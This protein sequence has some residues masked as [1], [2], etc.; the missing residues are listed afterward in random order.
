MTTTWTIAIDWD[1]NG[2]YTGTYDDVTSRVVS[3]EW[4]GGM[5]EAF[6]D[7]ADNSVL[8]LVLDNSD[9]RYSPEYASSPLNTKVLPYRPIRIQSNDG[10]TTR[11]HWVGW[12][13]TIQPDVGLYGERLVHITAAGALQFFKATE[14]KLA[15]QQNK[16]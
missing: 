7:C 6:Q 3:A 12:V 8:K 1:R 5:R 11:D 15:L 13:E 10:T 9:K 4:F 14:T 2:D 16:R